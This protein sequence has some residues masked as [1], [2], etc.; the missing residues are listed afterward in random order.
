MKRLFLLAFLCLQATLMSADVVKG[1]VMDADSGEPLEDAMVEMWMYPIGENWIE[2]E[3]LSTDSL[4]YF[5]HEVDYMAK[6]S[7]I[8]NYFGYSELKK[9]FNVKGGQD[10]LDLGDLKLKMSAE[11]L[12]EL[13]VKGHAKRFFMKGDT[14]VFNP[15]AFHLEDGDRL[16]TLLKKLKFP[17]L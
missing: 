16:A 6:M 8:I 5:S 3:K 1:R 14:V 11:L 2:R 7:L 10:T 9:S 17:T 13:E 12:K 15:D 4:G